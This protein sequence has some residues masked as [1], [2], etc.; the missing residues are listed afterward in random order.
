MLSHVYLSVYSRLGNLQ[1]IQKIFSEDMVDLEDVQTHQQVKYPIT[2][3][4]ML[5]ASFYTFGS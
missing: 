1:K 2:A 4:M 5:L 3:P